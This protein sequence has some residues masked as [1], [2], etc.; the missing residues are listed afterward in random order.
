G[1]CLLLGID[2][3]GRGS[4]VEVVEWRENRESGVVESWR[5]NQFGCYSASYFKRGGGRN[6]SGS[7]PQSIMHLLSDGLICNS[8]WN[9]GLGYPNAHSSCFGPGFPI[10]DGYIL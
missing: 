1:A 10:G 7:P 2:G 6:S 5:E 3:E 4:G 9:I 8:C